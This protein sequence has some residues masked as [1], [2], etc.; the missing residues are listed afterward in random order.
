[1]AFLTAGIMSVQY[2][3]AGGRPAR[4]PQVRLKTAFMK[5]M[6]MSQRMPSHCWAMHDTVSSATWRSPGSKA[7]NCKTSGHAGKK[8]SRPRAYT[9]PPLSM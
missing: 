7:F 4:L 3:V 6:A 2:S 5:S 9:V 8:G 1:M